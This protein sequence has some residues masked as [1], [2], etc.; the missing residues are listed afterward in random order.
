MQANHTELLLLDIGGV[1]LADAMPAIFEDI[2]TSEGTDWGDDLAHFHR[3]YL[4]T[5]LWSGQLTESQYWDSIAGFVGTDKRKEWREHLVAYLRPL[6]A[7]SQFCQWAYTVPIWLLSNHRA[8]WV[9]LALRRAE[10]ERCVS[11]CF[12]SSEQGLVKPDIR[13][14]LEVLQQW[15]GNPTS[16]LFVD[17]RQSNIEV[18]Q[19][20]GMQ[21]LR[22]DVDG[23]WKQRIN[24]IIY[25]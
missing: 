14:F 12:I 10:I 22:A 13:A 20:L 11:R 21:A 24:Y 5:K 6:V 25:R 15:H 23:E 2:A 4:S 3:D 7:A 9:Y 16:I 17:D 8:E 18:A 19:R 1:L